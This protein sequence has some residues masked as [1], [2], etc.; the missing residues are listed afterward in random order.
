[1]FAC[2]LVFGWLRVQAR[3]VSEKEVKN[4]SKPL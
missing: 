4:Q 1:M 2:F 3:M